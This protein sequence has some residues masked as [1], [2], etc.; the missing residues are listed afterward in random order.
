MKLYSVAAPRVCSTYH[1]AVLAF[2]PFA[3]DRYI[4]P[5]F[6]R[7]HCSSVL[8]KSECKM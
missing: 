2:V 7:S 8:Q 3:S 1:T 4:D 6:Y 5:T